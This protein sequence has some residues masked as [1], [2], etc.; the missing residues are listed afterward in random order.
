MNGLFPSLPRLPTTRYAPSTSGEG[1]RSVSRRHLL[2]YFRDP[3]VEIPRKPKLL[4]HGDSSG[5][6]RTGAGRK[7]MTRQGP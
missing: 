5:V 3:D 1:S 2:G 4:E 6:K 7:V